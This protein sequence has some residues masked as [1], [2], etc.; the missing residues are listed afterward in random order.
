MEGAHRRRLVDPAQGD[1]TGKEPPSPLTSNRVGGVSDF[2][3]QIHPPKWLRLFN[4]PLPRPG[5]PYSDL[6]KTGL[7]LPNMI[8]SL[9]LHRFLHKF[10]RL[11]PKIHFPDPFTTNKQPKPRGPTPSS[12]AP[13]VV[14]ANRH[15]RAFS[16][17]REW[18]WK[19]ARI[20]RSIIGRQKATMEDTPRVA[21]EVLRGGGRGGRAGF[22]A[23][24]VPGC[25]HLVAGGGKM[26]EGPS[27]KL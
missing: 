2:P 16:L 17:L 1:S 7:L 10:L 27:C 25:T 23:H 26:V 6:S 3:K 5:P 22:W 21:R 4:L 14:S 8:P 12:A 20:V 9:V 15:E 11:P 24:R 13:S 19:V 18:P